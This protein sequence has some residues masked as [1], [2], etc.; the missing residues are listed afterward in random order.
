VRAAAVLLLLAG[1]AADADDLPTPPV[2]PCTVEPLSLNTRD[3]VTPAT[4]SA[5][6]RHNN[7]IR[8]QCGGM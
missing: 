6:R 2:Q 4:L 3:L 5:V 7:D 1:C 8:N